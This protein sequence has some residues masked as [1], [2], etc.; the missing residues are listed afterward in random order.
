MRLYAFLLYPFSVVYDLVT[1]LRNE[2]FDVGWKKSVPSPIPTIVVGNLS[3]GGTGKTPMVEFL[4][5][6][7]RSKYSVGVLSRGY[8]RKT[9]G[10]LQA[11]ESSTP[12]DIG[13]EPFQIY[14]NFER[15]IPVF[16]GE[17]RVD[18]LHRIAASSAELDLIILDDAFQH[19]YVMSGFSILL[20]TYSQPFFSDF[21]MPAGRL[22]ES[23]KGANRAD[24]VIITKCPEGLQEK[25]KHYST[26]QVRKY[27]ESD[28]PVLFSSINYGA[29]YPLDL[30]Y[31]LGENVILLSGLADDSLLKKY[32]SE[33]YNLLESLS[34]PDH[35]EYQKSDFDRFR[36]IYLNHQLHSPVILT[37]AKDAV[38]VKSNAPEGF[39]A[40]IPIFV[41]PIQV[42][43]N[44][45]DE[46]LLLKLIQQKAFRKGEFK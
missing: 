21:L 11:N 46:D 43:F 33:K 22:R 14:Q 17:K 8:G 26:T 15:Q 29:P 19:R 20:T 36:K 44:A 1:S 38:K 28:I 30:V 12:S 7:L 37:T 9:K 16:A 10:Y 6:L 31:E 41:L 45:Q 13:D 42:Q 25:D 32:V 24:V 18:A 2:L 35:Y 3:V 34:F 40:E 23:R 5:R 39:L 4:I 27:A